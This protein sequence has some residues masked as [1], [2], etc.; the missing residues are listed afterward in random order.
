MMHMADKTLRK[1]LPLCPSAQPGMERSVVFGVVGEAGPRPLLG[2]LVEPLP[3][4]EG[5]LALAGPVAPTEIF[6]FAAP[7]AGRGC[8]HFDGSD[9]RLAARVVQLLPAVVEGLPPCPLRPG[10]RWWQQEGRAA[11]L[12]C[13]QVVSET[14]EPSELL[15]LVADPEASNG[16]ELSCLPVSQQEVP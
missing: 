3:V 2:Y 6:R 15:R 13:P 9:C 10:C 11:C 4:T 7:C 1:S 8:R 5:V 14:C 12:R 16:S